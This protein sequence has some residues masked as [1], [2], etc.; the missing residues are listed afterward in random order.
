MSRRIMLSLPPATASICNVFALWMR[1]CVKAFAPP[2]LCR[3]LRGA[4]KSS[5]PSLYFAGL[6][7]AGSFGPLLRFVHGTEFAARQITAHIAKSAD[8]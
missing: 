3:S 5:V 6:A 4:S 1:N 8:A 2:V 7:A